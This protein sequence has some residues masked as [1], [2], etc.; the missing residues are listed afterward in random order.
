MSHP[1]MTEAEHPGPQSD[2]Q[3][4][5]GVIAGGGALATAIV[6]TLARQ[7]L[8]PF[9]VVFE[10]EGH[11]AS[12]FSAVEH[13]M[14]PLEDA[15]AIPSRLK[16]AC[17]TR[18]VLAGHIGRRPKLGKVR[19]GLS[20]L[21]RIPHI[22]AAFRRGD[23]GLLRTIIRLLE[24]AGITVV[25]AHEVVPNLLAPE[26][27]LTHVGPTGTDRKDVEAASQAA[28]AIGAL[29]IGQA[30]VA[31]GGRAIALEGIEGTDGLLAR[32]VDLRGHGRLAGKERGVL[33]KRCKPQQDMRADLPAIGPETIR[34]AHAAGL[35]GVAVDARRSFI[36]DFDQTIAL[37]DEYGMFVIGLGNSGDAR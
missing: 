4:R 25:G 2:A 31:V 6:N 12:D 8:N 24:K 14:L 19:W 10:G 36:L 16:R 27:I 15:P 7:G 28:L 33:V 5:I 26:G 23:D 20:T 21:A 22:A 35:A 18:L 17:V 11:E 1:T 30:A 34:G 3:G 37:A 29:D 13:L 32:T 9:V